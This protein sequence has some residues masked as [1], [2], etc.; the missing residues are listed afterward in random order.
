MAQYE[1][2]DKQVQ[3]LKAFLMDANIK[4]SVATVIVGLMNVL[5]NPIKK[6]KEDDIHGEHNDRKEQGKVEP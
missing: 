1:L 3:N 6:V 4:G 5:D 2:T